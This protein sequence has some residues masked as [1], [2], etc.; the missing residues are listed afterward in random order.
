LSVF[1]LLGAM[2]AVVIAGIALIAVP[3]LATAWALSAGASAKPG[4]AIDEHW[5]SPTVSERLE[6]PSHARTVGLVPV[7]MSLSVRL[8]SL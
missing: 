3:A 4:F 5:A 7:R 8:P 1:S 6:D 2:P